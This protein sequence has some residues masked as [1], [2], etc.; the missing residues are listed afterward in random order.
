MVH[1]TWI[2]GGEYKNRINITFQEKHG[3]FKQQDKVINSKLK[4]NQRSTV[5][6]AL[7]QVYQWLENK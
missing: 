1:Y 5:Q 3:D 4:S 2:I 6:Y 7:A